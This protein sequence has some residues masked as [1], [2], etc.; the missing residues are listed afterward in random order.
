M[1]YGLTVLELG[2][3]IARLIYLH[4]FHSLHPKSVMSYDP[5]HPNRCFQT[6]STS[7][8]KDCDA[9]RTIPSYGK[10]FVAKKDG[11]GKYLVTACHIMSYHVIV[12]FLSVAKRTGTHSTT[13]TSNSKVC[14]AI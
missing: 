9:I 2:A 10:P 11:S 4:I 6:R 5:S 1:F 12:F 14:M 13:L 7:V 3:F 8:S